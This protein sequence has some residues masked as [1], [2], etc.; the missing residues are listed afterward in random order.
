MDEVRQLTSTKVRST[1]EAQIRLSKQ[2][3]AEG[4]T[5]VE[6][7]EVFRS[8]YKLNAR[9]ALRLVRGWSQTDAARHWNDRWPRE[10]KTFKNFSY[11]EQWPSS[12]GHAPSLEILSRLAELY[13]CAVADLLVDQSDHRRQDAMHRA[14]ADLEQLPAAMNGDPTAEGGLAPFVERLRDGDAQE[15][16]R[17]AAVWAQQVDA[18]IDRRSLLVKLS[19]ALTLAASSSLD[20]LAQA[21]ESPVTSSGAVNL[22][23]IWRSEYTYFSSG[24]Q[25]EF[26]DVHYVVIRQTGQQ[27]AVT[28]LAHETSSEIFLN[29]ALDGLFATGTWQEH[30]SPTGYYQGAV[31]RGAIQLLVSPSLTQ[32]TGKWIGFGKNFT[33]NNGDWGLTLETRSTTAASVRRYET[34]I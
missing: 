21:A 18:S 24:R 22:D 27:I 31:Y 5:W 30:T 4:K 13:E 12:T 14:R 7:A 3:R 9:V 19:F 15:L 20:A 17:V 34:K 10:P 32:M 29:L 28:S 6:V 25:Q 33:I 1:K 26:T 11:W 2:L 8:E 23:G 16:A